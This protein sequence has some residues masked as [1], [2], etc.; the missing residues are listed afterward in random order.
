[1][2]G[3]DLHAGNAAVQGQVKPD[4]GVGD[5]DGRAVAGGVAGGVLGGVGVDGQL[6]E[7]ADQLEVA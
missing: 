3:P 1:V 2:G 4:Q 7:V 5:P 6:V